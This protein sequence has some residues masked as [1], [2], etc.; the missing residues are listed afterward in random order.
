[1]GSF[2]ASASATASSDVGDDWLVNFTGTN[3]GS[4]GT[5]TVSD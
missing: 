5:T 4:A 2:S 3:V 1:M